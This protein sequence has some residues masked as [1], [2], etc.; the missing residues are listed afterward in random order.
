[1]GVYSF[2][3]PLRGRKGAADDHLK[4]NRR[5]FRRIPGG[6]SRL[7]SL[8][9]PD[10][11]RPR[12]P[13]PNHLPDIQLVVSSRSN[14]DHQVLS[15]LERILFRPGRLDAEDGPSW[16]ADRQSET[17]AAAVLVFL[18]VWNGDIRSPV[19]THICPGP[20]CC[21][22]RDRTIDK[23]IAA[24]VLVGLL[25]G[26]TGTTPAAGRWGSVTSANG[27]QVGGMML[28]GILPAAVTRCFGR[29][30]AV[31]ATEGEDSQS[32]AAVSD[33]VAPQVLVPN[34]HL[35]GLV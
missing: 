21:A 34:F 25:P 4:P 18:Q 28:H 31:D 22:N 35:P 2:L 15:L 6:I 26:W 8:R 17:F 10:E 33:N 23:M 7:G 14:G 5:S 16:L 13:L 11:S 12:P 32:T 27:V 19:P 30:S 20:E 3:R 29:W 9:G 1:M 24:L